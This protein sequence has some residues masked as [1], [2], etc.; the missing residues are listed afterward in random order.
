MPKND[1]SQIIKDIRPLINGD[2][3]SDKLHR[4]AFSTDASIYKIEPMCVVAPENAKDVSV[5]VE[6]AAKKGIPVCGRGAG[7][8][9][10]G[11][12][13]TSGIVLDMARYMNN[14]LELTDS[15]NYAVCQP[16]VVLSVLNE[17]LKKY[18]RKIGS[19]PSSGNRATIGG[20]V[21]NN[22]TGSHW[23]KYGYF[24]DHV[25]SI[26]AVLNDGS[27]AEITND[28]RPDDVKDNRLNVIARD[29]L[30]TLSDKKDLIEKSLPETL[31]NRSGYNI[32][33]AVKDG[34]IDLARIL[35][36]SEGTLALFTKIK[37]RTVKEP[38]CKAL[39]QLEF[40]SL[41]KM[42]KAVPEVVESGASACEL[43][44][45]RLLEMAYDAF[46]RYR[47]ILPKDKKAILLVEH[48]GEDKQQ[49]EAKIER[50]KHKIGEFAA[51]V[52]IFFDEEQQERLWK[53]R[54]EAVPLLT[55]TKG[56]SHPVACIEDISVDNRKLAEY[57]RG[58]E[59]LEEKY[60]ISM[61]YYGHAGDGELHIRPFLDLSIQEDREKMKN[62]VEDVFNLAWSLGG[63]I[64]GEHAD[65]LVRAAFV[66][67]QYGDEY[68]DLLCKVKK[69][70]DPDDILNPG[71]IINKDPDVLLKDLRAEG[72]Y[73][74]ERL[75]TS[76]Y[77]DKD[78][79][80]LELD[81]CTGCGLC[82]S[83]DSENR[84][85]PVFRALGEELASSRA[86]ANLLREWA[87]GNIGE[88]TFES[89]KFK[90]FLSLCVNC[91]ACSRQCP[92]GVDVSKLV[93]A[94]RTEYFKRRR[95]SLSEAFMSN[96]RFFSMLGAWTWFAA[97]LFMKIPVFSWFMEKIIGISRTR[98]LPK[99][100]RGEFLNKAD[101][102]LK[103]LKVI[104]KPVDKAAYFVDTFVNFND[105]EIGRAVLKVLNHNG[106]D[107]VVPKQRPAPIPA[108]VYGDVNRARSDLKYSVKYLAESVKAGY[109]IICSE[110]SAALCL[111][112]ELKYYVKNEDAELVSENTFEL[113]E[114]L[115]GLSLENKLKPVKKYIG[116]DFVYHEPCHVLALERNGSCIDLL[117][118][119]CDIDVRNLQ[120]GC[121]GLAGTFGM[122]KKNL[123]LS[124]MISE[125]LQKALQENKDAKILTECSAC[126]M[127]IKH[128]SG[129]K[130]KHPIEILADCYDL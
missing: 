63:S 34:K 99:F 30:E 129:S 26:E 84:M 82:L 7:S 4:V 64:S 76:L 98:E 67:G 35:A 83:K 62:L 32:S 97:N 2:V 25:E 74:E 70:F 18:N 57:I 72:D 69:I 51:G 15:G 59:R 29:C 121:C 105:H 77:F 89:S 8:G 85:C 103:K 44:G 127:Q 81:Q 11:E 21:A 68:Y 48:D 120:G 90:K 87:K 112:D 24:A 124:E 113:I 49:V 101:K 45:D 100:D 53:S 94:A 55:R 13:L 52:K 93:T 37:L 50:T 42:A 110:P 130:V 118:K 60:S 91:K 6:Y 54:K 10:A 23:L 65:G 128:L 114:Y 88:D 36:G 96:N 71:K 43:M 27:I 119:V 9:V 92:S 20:C 75:K 22:A 102:Y 3:Y 80:L 1:A 31:R 56:R 28:F 95:K 38:E 47:D 111:K 115:Y 78:E 14:I 12:S 39:F 17:Q 19:D 106:I 122:Q 107:V 86:K 104:D 117:K 46:P 79:F 108:I 5:V 125:R 123:E 40:D 116:D 73:S 66:R 33:N 41:D 126:G 58:L 61:A 16:G 109:K